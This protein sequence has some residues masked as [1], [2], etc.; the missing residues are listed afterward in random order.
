[1]IIVLNRM[2][3]A[4]YRVGPSST[5]SC[6]LSFAAE[7][8]IADVTVEGEKKKANKWWIIHQEMGL[9]KKSSCLAGPSFFTRQ[10]RK[11][12]KKKNTTS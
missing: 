9:G 5:V 4:A 10:K 11:E 2:A 12:K 8:D 6:T 1:M 7:I 3:K